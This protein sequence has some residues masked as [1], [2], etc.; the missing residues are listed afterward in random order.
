ME[1]TPSTILVPDYKE[2]IVETVRTSK[3]SE[4]IVTKVHDWLDKISENTG[5]ILKEE[6]DELTSQIE[7]LLADDDYAIIKTYR[8]NKNRDDG[9]TMIACVSLVCVTGVAIIAIGL[10]ALGKSIKK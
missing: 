5:F 10:N 1:Q 2:E 7:D 6:W 4:C 8:G 3:K 9:D